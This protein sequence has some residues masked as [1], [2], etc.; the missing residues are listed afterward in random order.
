VPDSPA[1]VRPGHRA[2]LGLGLVQDC[3]H[4]DRAAQQL[5]LGEGVRVAASLG[6]QLICLPELTLYPYFASRAEGLESLQWTPEPVLGG[7][8]FEFLGGLAGETGC[9]LQASLFE[10]GDGGGIGYN[11]SICVAPDR[12]L[13]A[14]TRKAHLPRTAGYYEDRYFRP[15][16]SGVPVH[17]VHGVRVGFPTC[18]DQW[19]PELARLYSLASA[20]LLVF[21]TAIGSEPDHPSFDTAP[22]W[23]TVMRGNG[24]MNGLFM[25]AVNRVGEENGITFYGSSFISDPYGRVLASAG[26]AERAVIVAQIDPDQRRDW[27]DL[28]PFLETRRPEIY[29]ELT[30]QPGDGFR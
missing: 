8:T 19:F 24:I 12:T 10:E 23:Q 27:L 14:A 29:G 17:D 25:A 30:K 16:D 3:W 5:S 11:T 28:F 21:P 26:P 18:W 1:K 9:H 4:G 20:E 13:V 15:G 7:P 22:L 6:V 2:P